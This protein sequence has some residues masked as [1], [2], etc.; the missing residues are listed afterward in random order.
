MSPGR[1]DQDD[2]RLLRLATQGDK[3]AFGKLYERYLDE[4][5]RFVFYRLGNQEEAEDIT[6]NAFIKTWEYL[7]AIEKQDDSIKNF[8]NW[9]YQVSKNLIVDYYRKK[10]TVQLPNGTYESEV[11]TEVI[12]EK[13]IRSGKLV[14]AIME[15]KPEYQQI[16]L[17]R[18]VN[19]LSHEDTAEI[20][21]LN[22]G[23]TRILQYR[24]LKK[25]RKILSDE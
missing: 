11:S 1:S 8:R 19:Q 10:K 5:Y 14:H 23:Q 20:M 4:I 22:T 24:A 2:R 21:G 3:N 25:L 7:P 9:L 6:A 16:I 18:F 12:S 15:L 17:L 13:N